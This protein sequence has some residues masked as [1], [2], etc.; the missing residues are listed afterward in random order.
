MNH[1]G[2]IMAGGGGTRFWPLSRQRM[3]KQLLNLSGHD[4]MV[5]EAVDRMATVI[6]KSNIFIVTADVQAPAMITATDGK[7][8]PKNILAEPAARNTAACIGYSAME[9]VR[10]YGD[11]VMIITPADHYIK[12][13]PALTEIFKT[14]ILAA[15]KQDKLITIGLKPT[16]PSTG[17]GYI[18][19]D[20]NTQ[21]ALKQVI[22]FKEKPDEE[23][24]KAYVESGAYAWNSGMF[25]WK[26]SLIL[27]K[28]KE[29][30]PDIYAELKTIGDAMNTAKEQQVLHD[31]YPKI[32][33]ISID[34]AVMEPGA[35]KGDVLVIP[36]DCGWND[37]GSWD[38]ME[39]LHDSD[40]YG[41]IILGDAVAVD[42]K[43]TVI[44]SSSRTVTAVDVENL[45]I[46]ETPD[47]VMVCPKDRAQNVK[48]IVDALNE[49]GRKELL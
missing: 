40:E 26:A 48:K 10:K 49:A 39:I 9:I 15:E 20:P 18:K 42:V 24:A 22:E 45:I 34:Y 11:G 7:V 44:C 41:N 29:Y 46:V 37:V 47:A 1:Y 19:Y 43:N 30:V 25:I 38:M 2:V 14:A 6:G 21:D 13:V 3:P 36:G 28:L 12:D 31:V 23:T 27:A 4:L 35:A 17:F 5:N 33:K 8:F 16:F 32:R